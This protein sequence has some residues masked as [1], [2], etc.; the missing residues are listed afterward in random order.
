MIAVLYLAALNCYSSMSENLCL[1]TE[2]AGNPPE[3]KARPGKLHTDLGRGVLNPHL[4]RQGWCLE[5]PGASEGRE[6]AAVR[7]CCHSLLLSEA[8]L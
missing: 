8:A 4:H 7:H 2:Y 1:H 5:F 6:K 3:V